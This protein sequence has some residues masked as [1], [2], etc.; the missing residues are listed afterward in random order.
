MASGIRLIRASDLQSHCN[1]CCIFISSRTCD[2]EFSLLNQSLPLL[3][4]IRSHHVLLSSSGKKKKKTTTEELLSGHETHIP[5]VLFIF[6]L[7]QDYKILFG[8]H[9]SVRNFCLKATTLFPYPPPCTITSVKLKML[10]TALHLVN[11]PLKNLLRK[12]AA[13]GSTYPARF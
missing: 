11:N 3:L 7:E 13:T 12:Q 4:S 2:Q 10:Q 8:R 6:N 1:S 9:S 5:F